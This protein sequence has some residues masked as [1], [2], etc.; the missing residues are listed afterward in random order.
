MGSLEQNFLL[1]TDGI[2]AFAAELPPH[3]DNSR[4]RSLNVGV[5]GLR[6]AEGVAALQSLLMKTP[7]LQICNLCGNQWTA[8][9]WTPLIDVLSNTSPDL[10]SLDLSASGL[11][12]EVGG[13]VVAAL[14]ESLPNLQQLNLGGNS[15]LH[16]SGVACI[17]RKELS[18]IALQSLDLSDCGLAGSAGGRAAAG[19]IGALLCRPSQN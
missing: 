19:A 14:L 1:S 13:G 16:D 12:N 15:D 11:A 5:C 10:M 18:D 9:G 6:G 4:W 3:L 8:A 17:V 7:G 2:Q